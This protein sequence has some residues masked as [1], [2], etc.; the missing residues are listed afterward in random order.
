MS[1]LSLDREPFPFLRLLMVVGLS[2]ILSRTGY[3]LHWKDL[4]V[5]TWAG[6]RGAVG[7]AL[8]LVVGQTNGVSPDIGNKVS[9]RIRYCA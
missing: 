1:L 6:L 7:L 4:L 5:V 8:A 3:P 2:P 9:T